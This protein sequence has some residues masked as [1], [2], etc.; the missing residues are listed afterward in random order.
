MDQVLSN[1]LAARAEAREKKKVAAEAR[2]TWTNAKGEVR[3]AEAAV[4]KILADLEAG[5]NHLPFESPKPE[6]KHRTA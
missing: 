5:Q 4:E 2:A 1:L 3:D 6:K